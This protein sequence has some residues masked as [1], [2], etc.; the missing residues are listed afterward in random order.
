M[1][2]EAFLTVPEEQCLAEFPQLGNAFAIL[3]GIRAEAQALDDD[4]HRTLVIK[5]AAAGIARRVADGNLAAPI[6]W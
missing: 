2:A 5:K 4:L 6:P 3:H 1:L